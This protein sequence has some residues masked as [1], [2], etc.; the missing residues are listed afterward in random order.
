MASGLALL[1]RPFAAS[2]D[3]EAD[4]LYINFEPVTDADD[5]ELTPDDLVLRYREDRLIGVT[6]L[7]ASRR[8][9]LRAGA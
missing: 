6:V 8:D 3:R 5:S 2:Y 7:N 1:N 9:Q 4:V